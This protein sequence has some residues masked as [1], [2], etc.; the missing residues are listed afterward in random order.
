MDRA[1]IDY[2]TVVYVTKGGRAYGEECV[3]QLEHA[4]QCA[5][6]AEEEGASDA[7]VAASLLHDSGHLLFEGGASPA[8]CGVDDRHEYRPIRMLR[9]HF[10]DA[11]LAP[12]RLHVAAKRYLCAIDPEYGAALSPASLRS[13][14]LQGGPF[15]SEAAKRFIRQPHATAAVRLRTWDDR[16]KIPG[17][18]T[19]PLS[20]YVHVLLRCAHESADTQSET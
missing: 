10:A 8:R 13:L 16:A 6:Q 7:L 2:L 14:E 3:S 1:L 17:K 18:A 15:S 12:I 11:V 19:P 5:L 4:L 20:H 9:R